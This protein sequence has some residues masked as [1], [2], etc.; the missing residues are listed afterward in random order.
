M[1]GFEA[2]NG[3]RFF[4]YA[5]QTKLALL[6]PHFTDVETEA[7]TGDVACLRFPAGKWEGWHSALGWSDLRGE[8]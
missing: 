4:A 8:L 7:Q 2:R 3:V 5:F 1:R 6:A